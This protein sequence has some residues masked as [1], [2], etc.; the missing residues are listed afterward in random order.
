MSLQRNNA[1]GAPHAPLTQ[2]YGAESARRTWVRDIFN[3]TAVDYDRIES[4]MSAGSGARYRRLAL[5]RAGLTPGMNVLDVGTGTGLVAKQAR[6][7]VGEGGSVT[8]VDPGIG[9]LNAARFS[10]GIRAVAGLGERLPF[11]AQRFDFL[12]MGYALRHVADLSSL[13]AEYHRVLKPGATVCVL[14]ISRPMGRAA[15][16]LLKLYMRTIVPLLTRVLAR[17]AETATLMRYYWDTIETCVAP[18]VVLSA[19]EAAGFE[20]AERHV[21][22]GIFSE[23]RGR[24]SG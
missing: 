19:L 20:R 2:Y 21:E 7:I 16:A 22:M 17:R 12:S 18:E 5:L 13:F 15:H 4:V 14:E 6:R 23:Y 11:A 10:E 1:A 24:R 8:G 9:M 3:R